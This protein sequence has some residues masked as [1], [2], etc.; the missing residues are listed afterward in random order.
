MLINPY[1][2]GVL[3]II[4]PPYPRKWI[5]KLNNEKHPKMGIFRKKRENVLKVV[6]MVGIGYGPVFYPHNGT[7]ER[8]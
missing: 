2:M 5:K 3:E 6:G 8:K 4:Y 1:I 7:H